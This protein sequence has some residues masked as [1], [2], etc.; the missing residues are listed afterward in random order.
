MTD[1]LLIYG[2]YGYAGRLIARHAVRQ[3]LEPILAGR[4]AEPV[5]RLATD[6]GLDHAV[7]SLEHPSVVERAVGDVDVVLNCAGPFS[8]TATPMLSACLD[9]GDGLPRYRGQRRRPRIY[10]RARDAEASAAE[11]AAPAR[12]GVRRRRDGLPGRPATR[13]RPRGDSPDPRH[14]W[15]RHVLAGDAQVDDRRAETPRRGPPAG[16]AAGRADGLEDP[17]VRL[18]VRP[19]RRP[20]RCRG[21]DVSTAYYTTGIPNIEDV[22]CRSVL[23]SRG[24]ET[25]P[26][27]HA[28]GG[29]EA[30]PHRPEA[31]RPTSRFPGRRPLNAHA[32][33]AASTGKLSTRTAGG[34][35]RVSGRRT[36]TT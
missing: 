33:R 30:G 10:R 24:D 11:V 5:E 17:T 29:D 34:C 20:S 25:G 28:A 26:A 21:G 14:R 19:Q 32:A 23:R 6:L 7:F 12:R 22:R 31:T 18:R 8:A 4:R 36:R 2:A 1:G 27:T 13:R 3:G 9:A 15:S 16:P 35:R